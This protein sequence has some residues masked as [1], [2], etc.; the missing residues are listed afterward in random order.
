MKNL[1]DILPEHFLIRSPQ[2]LLEIVDIL[3][4]LMGKGLVEEIQGTC[5]VSDIQEG[6]PF[7]DDLINIEFKSLKG[8]RY[9]LSCE[10]YRGAGG[11]F[12]ILKDGM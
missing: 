12:K 2:N 5:S 6:Q 3:K 10:T 8:V 1:E 4:N 9:I 7:P 11:V